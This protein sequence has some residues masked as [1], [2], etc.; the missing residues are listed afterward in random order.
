MYEGDFDP[1]T[2]NSTA[3]VPFALGQF[4]DGAY[5]SSADGSGNL[6]GHIVGME[7]G[8]A[9]NGVAF[10]RHQSS[11][12]VDF[13]FLSQPTFG[14]SYPAS[15]AEFRQGTGMPNASPRIGPVVISEIMYHPASNA[16]EFVEL[17]NIT[18]ANVD[19]SGWTLKGAAFTFPLDVVLLGTT[20]I[21]TEQFR[22][23]NNVPAS[24]PIL[25]HSFD[26]QNDGEELELSKPSDPPGNPAIRVDRVRYN[27]KSP[28]PAEADGGGP[29][30]ERHP[31]TAYGN[32][33]LNWR[34]VKIGGT[35][36]RS[37][38]FTNSMAIARHSSWRYHALDHNLG[39][40]WQ[41]AN[42]NDSGWPSGDGI[43]GFG[44]PFVTTILS[45]THGATN[46]PITT[47]FR[48]EFVIN[49]S[50]ALV[51]NLILSV[52]YDDGFIAFVNG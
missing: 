8:A 41:A 45:N 37:G 46:R 39:T 16:N 48:K 9:D 12:G 26:L 29:S 31:V 4:G 30:L 24:V 15:N 27:D 44:Q 14:V 34:T 49:D 5:L 51:T 19:L 32:E 10:G 47:Y 23:S 50:L 28:W 22:E 38:D 1:A 18:S 36:G 25:G 40:P 17:F 21:T 11:V 3:L 43:L 33:P 13:T 20:N 7:F 6:D 52:N 35:P 2:T 42:Y